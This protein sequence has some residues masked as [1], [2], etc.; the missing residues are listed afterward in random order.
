MQNTVQNSTVFAFL[1]KM[2]PMTYIH[3]WFYIY[4]EYLKVY[5]HILIKQLFVTGQRKQAEETLDEEEV[6]LLLHFNFS[7]Q[8]N[9]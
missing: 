6:I 8:M 4:Q 3:D 5:L 2:H 1:C 7:S 9:L